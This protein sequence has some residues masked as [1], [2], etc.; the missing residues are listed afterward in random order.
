[1][2]ATTITFIK[3]KLPST[4]RNDHVP[5]KTKAQLICMEISSHFADRRLYGLCD[6]ID[7]FLAPANPFMDFPPFPT[8][9]PV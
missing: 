8:W 5:F 2:D 6:V 1:M 3:N 9:E 4:W 7:C